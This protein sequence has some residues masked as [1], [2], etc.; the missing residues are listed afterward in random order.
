MAPTRTSSALHLLGVLG[1]LILIGIILWIDVTTTIWQEMVILS[2][3]AAGLVSFLLT[4]VFISKFHERR[5]E[6]R[7]APVTHMALTSLLHNLADENRSDLSRGEIVPRTLDI[8]VASR[9]L[10]KELEKLRHAVL[11]E[12]NH[13]ASVLGTW[14]E[15]LTSTGDNT[16]ILRTS[17]ELGLQLGRVRDAALEV[18]Q[19]MNSTVQVDLRDLT[20][21]IEICN[22][23]HTTLITAL[24][25]RLQSHTAE[26]SNL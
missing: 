25:D 10:E 7:W 8:P 11:K 21:E 16:D 6:A 22:Q 4:S 1:A 23:H 19:R 9:G 20:H 24:E 18:E 3:L 26:L 17:A 13:L 12:Q 2:G 14:A 15:F 5:I